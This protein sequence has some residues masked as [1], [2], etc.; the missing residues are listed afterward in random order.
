MRVDVRHS[1]TKKGITSAISQIANG[2]MQLLIE[3]IIILLIVKI[4]MAL[5]H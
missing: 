3:K 2:K 5:L 4:L 1:L